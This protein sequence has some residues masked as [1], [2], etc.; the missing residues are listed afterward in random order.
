MPSALTVA[1]SL[2][3][4][5]GDALHLVLLFLVVLQAVSATPIIPILSHNHT[6][7]GDPSFQCV[8]SE[9]W[10]APY[11]FKEDCYVAVQNLYKWDFRFHP[12]VLFTFYAGGQRPAH[13]TQLVQT[14]KRYTETTCTL[15]LVTLNMVNSLGLPGS[16]PHGTAGVDKTTFREIYEA[17]RTLEDRCVAQVGRPGKL[18]WAPVGELNI[19]WMP[20]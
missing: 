2:S 5:A 7:L 19:R 15:A 3:W 17:A 11:F 12:D 8:E 20:E 16:I 1:K 18:G 13:S 4:R 6:T 9:S 14:P 10:R